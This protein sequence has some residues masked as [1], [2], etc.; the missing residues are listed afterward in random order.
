M[1]GGP[2]KYS[3][4]Y[5]IMIFYTKNRGIIVECPIRRVVPY[6]EY[7]YENKKLFHN[8]KGN[9]YFCANTSFMSYC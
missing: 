5:T 8:I 1:V 7:F 2:Y 6:V 4:M 3:K 9:Y